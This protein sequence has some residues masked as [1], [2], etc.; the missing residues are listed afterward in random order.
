MIA[1]VKGK[2]NGTQ[3]TNFLYLLE[4]M[5]ISLSVCCTLQLAKFSLTTNEIRVLT[6]FSPERIRIDEKNNSFL[7]VFCF[8]VMLKQ[9]FPVRW[10][11]PLA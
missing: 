11:P 5:A 4:L 9:F 2:K 7:C 10:Y 6:T 3:V 1:P 8:Q